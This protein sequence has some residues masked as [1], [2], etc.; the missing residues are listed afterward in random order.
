MRILLI[1]LS[2][3]VSFSAL[4]YGHCENLKIK[5]HKNRI[6]AEEVSINCRL[7]LKE[8]ITTHRLRANNAYSFSNSE[9]QMGEKFELTQHLPL[10]IKN[11]INKYAKRSGPNC[12]NTALAP[13]TFSPQNARGDSPS[14]FFLGLFKGELELVGKPQYGDVVLFFEQEKDQ[15]NSLVNDDGNSFLRKLYHAGFYLSN[16]YIF[17]KDGL[18]SSAPYVIKGMAQTIEEYATIFAMSFYADPDTPD[19][20]K[21]YHRRRGEN[22]YYRFLRGHPEKPWRS[23]FGGYFLLRKTNKNFTYSE[24]VNQEHLEILY[25]LKNLVDKADEMMVRRNNKILTKRIENI[26]FN[27]NV[28]NEIENMDAE[29]AILIYDIMV[30]T[31]ILRDRYLEFGPVNFYFWNPRTVITRKVMQATGITMDVKRDLQIYPMKDFLL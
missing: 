14:H 31:Q 23:I 3:F 8:Q 24:N 7:E 27:Q 26:F 20:L 2:L 19:F 29:N 9:M 4:A 11:N 12:Y 16:D 13:N 15:I 30:T 28:V 22:E 17:T 25:D 10:F 5:V 18:K 1:G 6:F 21:W